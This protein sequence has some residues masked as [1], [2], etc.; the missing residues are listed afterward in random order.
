MHELGIVFHIMDSLEEVAKENDLTQIQSVTVEVGEV[1]TVIPEYLTDCWNWAIRKKE[2]LTGCEMKVETIHA[3]THCDGCG[4]DY[5]TVAHGRICP[6]CG[7]EKT[8]LITGNEINI[9]EITV[10]ES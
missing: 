4:R 1:S 7:S 5:D 3:V 6:H 2:L 9:K 8:W 10:P